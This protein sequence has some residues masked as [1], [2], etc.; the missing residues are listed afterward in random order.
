MRSKLPASLMLLCGNFSKVWRDQ[1]YSLL[2]L[3]CSILILIAQLPHTSRI[4]QCIT[5][6]WA[7]GCMYVASTWVCGGMYV[8]CPWVWMCT[9][10]CMCKQRPDGEDVRHLSLSSSILL[11]W[12]KVFPDDQETPNS[13]LTDWPEITKFLVKGKG[14]TQKCVCVWGCSWVARVTESLASKILGFTCLCSR[15]GFT[16][17]RS[18]FTLIIV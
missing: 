18:H 12:D 3:S 11:P 16:G 13:E 2:L 7:F 1:H 14:C 15:V 4:C 5:C 10:P 8:V 17:T 6:T 9:C